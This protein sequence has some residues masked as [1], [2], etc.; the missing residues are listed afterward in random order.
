[1]SQLNLL[2]EIEKC[3]A[4]MGGPFFNKRENQKHKEQQ[5]QARQQEDMRNMRGGGRGMKARANNPVDRSG[6]E[7]YT[8]HEVDVFKPTEPDQIMPRSQKNMASPRLMQRE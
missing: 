4:E 5:L 8:A 7:Q 1:M 3:K 2:E 6:S